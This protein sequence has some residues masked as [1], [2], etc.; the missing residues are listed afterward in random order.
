MPPP[1]ADKERGPF[2]VGLRDP[3]DVRRDLL[4]SSKSVIDALKRH[5]EFRL[6]R[7]EK[8]EYIRQFRSVLDEALLLGKKLHD[9]MPKPPG[10]TPRIPGLRADRPV[11]RP[12]ETA[13]AER[14]APAE[15][16]APRPMAKPKPSSRLEQL[17]DE[18]AR[19][20]KELQSLG[21]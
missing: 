15:R 6:L 5:E 16:Q 4:L 20:E 10:Q 14:P 11:P 9:L 18:L 19:V 2:Y 8:M 21:G 1:P 12:P 7:H 3:V 17:E 13:E